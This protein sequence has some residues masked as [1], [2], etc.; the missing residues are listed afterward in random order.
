MSTFGIVG[1]NAW[2]EQYSALNPNV[3]LEQTTTYWYFLVADRLLF[4]ATALEMCYVALLVLVWGIG[5]MKRM[6]AK[7]KE[8]K[9]IEIH[10]WD[11]SL[12][13]K[14]KPTEKDCKSIKVPKCPICKKNMDVIRRGMN[15]DKTSE[16]FFCKSC[17]KYFQ[18]K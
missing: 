18:K 1:I 8:S 15:F 7:A 9:E 12:L 10:L 5:D 3:T 6:E 14:Q 17:G 11:D 4:L 13:E 16:R 2:W